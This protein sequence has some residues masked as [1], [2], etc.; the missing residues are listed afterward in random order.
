MAVDNQRAGYFGRDSDEFG[1]RW[2]VPIQKEFD[3]AGELG[4]YQDEIKDQMTK[5]Y[6]VLTGLKPY[7]PPNKLTSNAK[8]WIQLTQQTAHLPLAT[9]S[10]ITEPL[11]ALSS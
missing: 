10:S 11:I 8:D 5:L 7:L 1:E 2:L 3:E 4:V 6:E 9:V